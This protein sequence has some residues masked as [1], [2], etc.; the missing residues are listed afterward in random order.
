M[1]ILW[2]IESIRVVEI[3]SEK[4]IGRFPSQNPLLALREKPSEWVFDEDSH[5][6]AAKAYYDWWRSTYIFK[7]KMKIDPL[8]GSKYIWH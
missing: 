3:S 6:T 4:L 7:D 8:K 5:L 1:I 2:N